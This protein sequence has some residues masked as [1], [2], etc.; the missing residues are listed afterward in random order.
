MGKTCCRTVRLPAPP[1]GTRLSGGR[2]RRRK[3]QRRG[4][5]VMSTK[6]RR[7][8]RGEG[9]VAKYGRDMMTMMDRRCWHRY[10][11]EYKDSLWNKS[12]V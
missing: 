1:S 3:R 12:S 11:I 7:G 4:G 6:W 5:G 10:V 2:S 8:G 9:L